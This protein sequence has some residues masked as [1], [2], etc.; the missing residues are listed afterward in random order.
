[1]GEQHLDPLA[2]A[3]RLVDRFSADQRTGN[4]VSALVDDARNFALGCLRAA[5]C[6]ERAR[7]TIRGPGTIEKCLA[8]MDSACCVLWLLKNL[9]RR[10]TAFQSDMLLAE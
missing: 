2:I 8:I 10:S 5:L 7:T 6:L 1:V 9:S 4:I 3:A